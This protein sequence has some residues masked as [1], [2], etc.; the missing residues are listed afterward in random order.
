[1]KLTFNDIFTAITALIALAALFNSVLNTR[2]IAKQKY[3]S[4]LDSLYLRLL[5]LGVEYPHLI[6]PANTTEY[7]T[8]F[9]GGDLHRYNAYAFIVWNVCETIFDNCKADKAL[10]RTWQPDIDAQDRLHRAWLQ[11]NR[12]KFKQSFLEHMNAL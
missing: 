4:D 9:I 11:D 12:K 7:Q 1:M 10:W 5:E 8:R 2:A 3:Y 6:D